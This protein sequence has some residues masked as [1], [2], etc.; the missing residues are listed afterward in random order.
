MTGRGGK[1]KK[2][3]KAFLWRSLAV[4]VAPSCPVLG[5]CSDHGADGREGIVLS[6]SL[7][8]SHTHKC[9]PMLP[10]RVD[11]RKKAIRRMVS[12]WLLRTLPCINIIPR[13]T[14]S[15]PSTILILALMTVPDECYQH[16]DTPP[17]CLQKLC[18][19]IRLL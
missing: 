14:P 10:C 15:S 4:V 1:K 17:C 7:S 12:G 9:T 13:V 19:L 18:V 5:I 2:V 16:T 11:R 8:L 3:T 6:F